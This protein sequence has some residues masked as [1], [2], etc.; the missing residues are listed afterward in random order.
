MNQFKPIEVMITSMD[1]PLSGTAVQDADGRMDPLRNCRVQPNNYCQPC[2]SFSERAWCL[3]IPLSQVKWQERCPGAD[4]E[5]MG[6]VLLHCSMAQQMET[7]ATESCH[8]CSLLM[9]SIRKSTCLIDNDHG[10]WARITAHHDYYSR[11]MVVWYQKG[12]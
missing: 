9:Q 6:E 10:L 4:K 12:A 7:G 3:Q 8:S 5:G 11:F 2:R 1:F